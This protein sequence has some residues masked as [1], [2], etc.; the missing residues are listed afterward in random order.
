MTTS[1]VGNIAWIS[2]GLDQ[3]CRFLGILSTER[4]VIDELGS[5]YLKINL[6]EGWD[7]SWSTSY[8]DFMSLG[9]AMLASIN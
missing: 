7:Q 5:D 4:P 8:L 3:K 9:F 6:R 2:A 1:W